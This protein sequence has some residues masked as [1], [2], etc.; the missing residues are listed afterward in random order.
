[1]AGKQ[2]EA[3]GWLAQVSARTHP[4]TLKKIS[5]KVTVMGCWDTFPSLLPLPGTALF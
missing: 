2:E 1:M 4:L 3:Q 5:A